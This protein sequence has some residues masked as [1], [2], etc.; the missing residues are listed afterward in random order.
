[1]KTLSK[2]TIA[3]SLCPCPLLAEGPFEEPFYGILQSGEISDLTSSTS[4]VSIGDIELGDGSTLNIYDREL[5]NYY[6][7]LAESASINLKSNA[8]LKV[9]IISEGVII[10]NDGAT[11]TGKAGGGEMHKYG[12]LA[13]AF[14]NLQI[15]NAAIS[16]TKYTSTGITFENV[17]LENTTVDS[18]V[19]PIV[20]ATDLT[21]KLGAYTDAIS[22]T[23]IGTHI[24]LSGSLTLDIDFSSYDLSQDVTITYRT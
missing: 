23:G 20:R 24:E 12:E 10:S 1:M 3:V 11:I 19:L 13:T 14:R 8:S 22:Y 21:L 9:D 7:A 15:S 6:Y 2:I 16:S 17:T 4:I 18:D 5:S